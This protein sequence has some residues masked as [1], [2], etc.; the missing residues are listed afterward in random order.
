[1]KYYTLKKFLVFPA[2]V[3]V[4]IHIGFK[5]ADSNM[6]TPEKSEKESAKADKLSK[7]IYDYSF[8]SIDGKKMKI[9]DFKGKKILFVNTA[10]QC[11]FTPQYEQLEAI[12]KKYGSKLVIIGFPSNDFGQQEPGPNDSIKTFCQ[13]NYGVT[14]TLSQKVDVKGDNMCDIYKWLT[15]KELNGK[16]DS[17]VKWNFQK[18]L[19]DEKGNF[20]EMFPSKIKPDDPSITTEIEK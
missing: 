18:Y 8:T 14:F 19:I 5:P 11:G 2:A 6:N 9:S 13:R 7:S 20:M 1:M 4:W 3:A 12:H 16:M 15:K 17:E 10:S